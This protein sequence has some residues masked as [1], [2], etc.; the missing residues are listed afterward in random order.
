[1]ISNHKLIRHVNKFESNDYELWLYHLAKIC[2]FCNLGRKVHR[3]GC[4]IFKFGNFQSAKKGTKKGRGQREEKVK[5]QGE[6]GRE[7]G[8]KGR[9]REKREEISLNGGEGY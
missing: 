7:K 4:I 9:K 3:Q 8:E 1:M 2:N 5:G 6:K